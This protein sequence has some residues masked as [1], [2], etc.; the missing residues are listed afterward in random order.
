M[1]NKENLEKVNDKYDEESKQ[2]GRNDD[3]ASVTSESDGN[4]LRLQEMEREYMLK[5]CMYSGGELE[6]KIQQHVHQA[7]IQLCVKEVRRK[8]FRYTALKRVLVL[9]LQLMLFIKEKFSVNQSGKLL[10]YPP[11]PIRTQRKQHQIF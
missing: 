8:N 11:L 2:G 6:R 9:L 10:L 4:D 5:E 7:Y 1:A 3:R